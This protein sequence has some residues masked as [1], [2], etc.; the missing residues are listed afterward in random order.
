MST[1]NWDAIHGFVSPGEYERFLLWLSAQV[2]AE[3]AETVQVTNPSADLIYGVEER[4]YRCKASG[5]TWRLVSPQA[6]YR[7]AWEPI[8]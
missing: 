8:G 3:V 2:D 5:Q 4:W 7:G 1:C 6:P